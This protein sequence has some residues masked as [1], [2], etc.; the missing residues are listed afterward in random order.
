M[1]AEAVPIRQSNLVVD[2]KV[3]T[4]VVPTRNMKVDVTSAKKVNSSVEPLKN[5][6]LDKS[7]NKKENNSSLKSVILSWQ[8]IPDAAMYELIVKNANTGEKIFSKYN[9]YA[10]G[11]QLDNDE[12]DFNNNL[13]WQVRGLN[14]DKIPISDYSE[15]KIVKQG[16]DFGV[17]WQMLNDNSYD[18]SGFSKADSDNYLIE[19]NV[20]ISPLKLTTHFDEMAYMPVYPVYSWIPVKNTEHYNID[21]FYVK[22]NNFNN[23]QKVASYKS[24]Q[25]MD[26]YDEKAYTNKGLYFY[27]I[28]AY[29][30]YSKKIAESK[31]SYF[32]VQT[33][34]V[35]VAALGDSITH[36]GG[37]VSTPPSFTLYNWET[38]AGIP[39][40]N[41][42]FSGNLTSDMLKRFDHDVLAFKPKLLVIMGGVNDIRTGIKADTV[43]ANL[44]AIK[45][46]CRKNSIIPVFLTVTSVNPP[47]MKSVAKLDISSGWQAERE[48]VNK[49]IKS[50]DYY[51]DVAEDM[52]D[53]RG[54]LVDNLTTDGLHPDY[55]GKKHIG[56]AVGDYLRLNFEYMLY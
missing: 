10:T 26:Y 16:T 6:V 20:N 31:N 9:I 13:I 11:Y 8:E 48:K 43:I 19:K 5:D 37:A 38:Y 15:A 18:Y 33:D 1:T 45:E 2:E 25:N 14:I 12:V 52:T 3:Q 29:D 55:E 23:I 4:V 44:T 36:G 41:I 30:K 56:E 39:V 24:P 42:G 27:N 47:K 7:V 21:V 54:Y 50:Q 53:E 49:W 17:N 35:K 28:Q 22:D 32:T 51:V 40:V 34:N 46:K